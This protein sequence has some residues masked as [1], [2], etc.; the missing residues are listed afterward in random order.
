MFPGA[1][2]KLWWGKK[3]VGVKADLEKAEAAEI[4]DLL[5]SAWHYKAE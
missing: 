5:Q 2:E 1:C 3:V 4:E